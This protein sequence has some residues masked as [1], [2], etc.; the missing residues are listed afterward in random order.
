[1]EAL[2]KFFKNKDKKIIYNLLLAFSVG[3]VLLVAGSTMFKDK[4]PPVSTA[5]ELAG[6]ATSEASPQSETT[7]SYERELEKRLE[8][9]LSLVEGAGKVKVMLTVKYGK[10]IIAAQDTDVTESVNE[11]KDN[12]G[13]TRNVQ[14]KSEKDTFVMLRQSNGEDY[15]LIL[16]EIEPQV[17][18]VIIIAEGGDDIAVKDALVRATYTVSGAQAHKVQVFKMQS[19]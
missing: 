14:S 9:I 7:Q 15:P 17:E 12:E 1:M 6:T 2:K 4:T 3:I 11:E 16:K 19:K 13:G 5:G 8:E 18:G 10:E